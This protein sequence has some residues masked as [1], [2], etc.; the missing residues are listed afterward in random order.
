[1][2]ELKTIIAQ[3]ISELRRSTKLTQMELA[4]RLNYS[5]KAVSKWERG[6]S[7]PDISVLKELADMFEVPVDYLLQES[8]DTSETMQPHYR[9]RLNFN[10]LIITM[11]S[12]SAV[13]LLATVVFVALELLPVQ[14]G[15]FLWMSYIYAIPLTCI[16]LLVFNSLWGKHIWNFLIISLLLWSCLL[17]IYLSYEHQDIFIIFY[18]GIPA[19]VIIILWANLKKLSKR[20]K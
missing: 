5:D 20:K 11:L 6:E 7:M 9:K 15:R 16:I 17:S 3:N 13:W 19:Q 4:E 14:P 12:A 2:D 8:H 10:R 18:I 1:M